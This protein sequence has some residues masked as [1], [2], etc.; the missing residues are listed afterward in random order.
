MPCKR[1]TKS[2]S[3]KYITERRKAAEE[4]STY[5]ENLRQ[6]NVEQLK[7]QV[8]QYKKEDLRGLVKVSCNGITKTYADLEDLDVYDFV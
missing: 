2:D 5:V 7:I 3:L 1:R 8:E 4:L 6:K